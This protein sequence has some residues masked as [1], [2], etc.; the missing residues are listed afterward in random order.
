[1]NRVKLSVLSSSFFLLPIMS[2]SI[3]AAEEMLIYR[4]G[5]ATP[6]HTFELNNLPTVS[7]SAEGITVKSGSLEAYLPY[8]DVDSIAFHSTDNGVTTS[9]TDLN[10]D[11][12]KTTIRFRYLDGQTIE[13]RG[14]PAGVRVEQ[15]TIDGKATRLDKQQ[16]GDL[17]TIRLHHLPKG[18]YIIRI[19]NQTYKIFKK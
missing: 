12:Q 3:Q 13:V 1:M 14:V 6:A 15:Y 17:L 9:M 2:T 8:N 11:S 7:F 10:D 18:V 16:M 4:G 5:S 19:D